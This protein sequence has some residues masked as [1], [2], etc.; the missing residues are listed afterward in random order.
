[1]KYSFQNLFEVVFE[2]FIQYIMRLMAAIF[3][4]TISYSPAAN[5]GKRE[6]TDDKFLSR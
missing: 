3:D 4:G 2:R 6:A 1:V 5:L